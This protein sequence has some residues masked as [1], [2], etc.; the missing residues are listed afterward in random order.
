VADSELRIVFK[1]EGGAEAPPPSAPQ[2]PQASSPV[3]VGPPASASPST[4]TPAEA[5]ELFQK[6]GLRPAQVG[7]QVGPQ[8]AGPS[9]GQ[10]PPPPAGP[11]AP[12]E[13]DDL[14][15]RLSHQ[16]EMR[17]ILEEEDEKP[18]R[19]QKAGPSAEPKAPPLPGEEPPP[20]PKPEKEQPTIFEKVGTQ[21]VTAIGSQVGGALAG[22]PGATAG[23]AA[24]AEGLA[25]LGPLAAA[26]GPAAIAVGAL[27]VGVAGAVAGVKLFVDALSAGADSIKDLSPEV[28]LANAENEIRQTFAML[29]RADQVGPQLANFQNDK[30]QINEQMAEIF[31]AVLKELIKIYEENHDLVE[32]A[33]VALKIVE[34]QI[35]AM[36]ADLTLIVELIK[37]M[38]T[39]DLKKAQETWEAHK[40]AND[41]TNRILRGEYDD[42]DDADFDPFN[43]LADLRV[44]AGLPGGDPAKKRGRAPRRDAPSGRVRIP[45]GGH[46]GGAGGPTA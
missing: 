2:I 34:V 38:G 15:T 29:R 35:P 8:A 7:A 9:P 17:A 25:A 37:G 3:P 33:K 19:R 1:D 26:A 44:M 11:P 12:T 43:F 24:A 6:Y 36:G 27:A 30:G 21:A 10:S 32:A 14:E 31:T 23:G 13:E 16:D 22:T 42:K 20:P 28:A 45:G 18:K 41:E 5:E 4:L 39:V 40:K 46:R